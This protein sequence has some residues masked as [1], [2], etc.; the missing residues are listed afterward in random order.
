[1]KIKSVLLAFIPGLVFL[2][3]WEWAVQDSDRLKFLFASPSLIFK[4]AITELG[5][6]SIWK[7]CAITLTEALLGLLFG[8]VLGTVSGLLLWS[9]RKIDSIAQPYVIIIG[10]IPVFALA[11][12]MIMW[13]G[14]GLLSKA[15]MAGFAVYFVSLV[16]AYEGAHVI[17]AQHLSYARSIG[18]SRLRMVLSIVVPGSVHWVLAGFRMNVGF[19]LTGAFIGEFISSEA[20]LGHY[21]L[22]AS[23]LYDMP[24]VFFGII[25]ISMLAIALTYIANLFKSR[26]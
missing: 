21:I 7:D 26:Y 23:S 12:V 19:A 18:A 16:Q 9:N 13:F 5:Q 24:K 4:T 6:I 10:S 8:T 11:P 17:A 14:I 25:L 3:L 2:G 15:I 20:G 22:K 1:M